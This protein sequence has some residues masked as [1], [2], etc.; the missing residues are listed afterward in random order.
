MIGNGNTEELI[1]ELRA[2]ES[3]D[4]PPLE[5]PEEVVEVVAPLWKIWHTDPASHVLLAIV[6][7][8][9]AGKIGGEVARRLRGPEITGELLMGM[10]LGNVWLFSGWRFFDFFREMHFLELLGDF[11]AITLLLTVGLHTDLKA[12]LRVGLSSFLVAVGGV[13]A[14]GGLGFL[15]GHFMLP[16][17]PMETKLFLAITLCATSV[18]I[19]LRVLDEL[20]MLGTVEGRII[21]GAAIVDDVIVLMLLGMISG[22]ALSGKI[23]FIG[24][25]ITGSIS[26]L[27]LFAVG[28]TSLRY[29]LIFGDFVTRKLP[30]SIKIAVVVVICLG[31]AF[32]AESIGLHTIVGAFGAGLLLQNVRLRDSEDKEYN[33][34]WFVKVAYWILV[35]ILFVRV[36]AQVELESFFDLK[37]VLVGLAITGAAILGKLFCSVCVA[38]RGVNRLAI[39]IA[40]I[41]RLEVTL[42]IAAVGK[43]L[44]VLSDALFSSV[45]VMVVLTALV[46]PPFLKM[47]LLRQKR[48]QPVLPRDLIP[49]KEETSSRRL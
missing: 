32:L 15:V 12:L 30:E 9:L 38:E 37:I 16:E 31:L 49:I 27:F 40:M 25:I 17:A 4:I 34:D 2:P 7:A 24:L 29:N 43:S 21:L 22:I 33:I 48:K 26:L 3:A 13:F 23:S 47:V 35:P 19:K 1:S 20:Q 8:L 42:V 36:G 10:F 41:P 44:E 46:S 5:I 11:G 45:V 18:A 28:I 6:I 39:G 14:P